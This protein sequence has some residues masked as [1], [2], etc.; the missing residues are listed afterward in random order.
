MC[1]L[2]TSIVEDSK[3]RML[4]IFKYD[5]K[6]PEININHNMIIMQE[7]ICVKQYKLIKAPTTMTAM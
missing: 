1:L 4:K 7:A 6:I 5:K 3:N 2:K